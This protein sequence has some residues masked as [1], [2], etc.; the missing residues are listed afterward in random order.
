MGLFSKKE[1]EAEDIQTELQQTVAMLKIIA[2]NL[3]VT[4]DEMEDKV[5]KLKKSRSEG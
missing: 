3:Q 1:P 5:E 2:L 4:A